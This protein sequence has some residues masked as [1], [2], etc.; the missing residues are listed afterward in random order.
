MVTTFNDLDC[1]LTGISRLRYFSTLNISETTRDIYGTAQYVAASPPQRVSHI[2]YSTSIGS[3]ISSIEWWY[4]Q[5]PWLNPSPVFKVTA[6]LKSKKKKK[7]MKTI[8]NSNIS[9]TVRLTDKVTIE[10]YKETIPSLSNDITFNDL[11]WLLTVISRSRYF[12]TLNISETTRDRA[13]V[14]IEDQ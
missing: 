3:H 5:H 8:S 14:T 1:S 9:I 6:Y 12:S 13:M 4:F 10:H 2:Y 7:M 11:Y